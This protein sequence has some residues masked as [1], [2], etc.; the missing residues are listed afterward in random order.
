M[1]CPN[2]GAE[3]QAD[4]KFCPS[5]G[6]A[7]VQ[8]NASGAQ[9]NGAW[10][11]GDPSSQGF[12]Q[13]PAFTPNYSYTPVQQAKPVKTKSVVNM[14]VGLASALVA[15]IGLFVPIMTAS[16]SAWG[17]SYSDSI[18]YMELM[19]EGEVPFMNAVAIIGILWIV[20]FSLIRHHK[21]ALLGSILLIFCEALV[22]FA[23]VDT[24]NGYG[25]ISLSAGFYF[26]LIAI[27]GSFVAAFLK[28]KKNPSAS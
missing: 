15:F 7:N 1:F 8:A 28:T 23:Y 24:Y 21:I 12:A 10:N 14:I 3:F 2:C 27:I 18:N 26:L 16:A 9:N 5:C 17:V 11:T 22:Y 13:D 19:K 4:A 6:A 25:I 20:V